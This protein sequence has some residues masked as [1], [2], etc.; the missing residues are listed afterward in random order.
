[1]KPQ[2]LF[3]LCKKAV[4]AWIDD[5]A[6]SMGAS[7]SYYT[8]F[9]LAPLLV[10]VIAIAGALFGREA[11]QGEVVAQLQG[12]IGLSLWICMHH[13]YRVTLIFP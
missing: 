11:V 5:Y 12:L 6:P 1:M 9:S 10:I 4:S 2:H 7:I 13:R 3:V 8:V